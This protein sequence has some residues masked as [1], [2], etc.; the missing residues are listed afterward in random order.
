MVSDTRQDHA[1]SWNAGGWFGSQLGS[2]LWLA[3]SAAVL[4]GRSAAVASIVFTLFLIINLVGVLLWR[5]RS[6]MSVFLAM[7]GLLAVFWVSSMAAIF[8]ID[9]AGLW[10]TLAV[11][12]RNNLSAPRT[13][14]LLTVLVLALGVMFRFR[15]RK[16]SATSRDGV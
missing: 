10:E 11:G 13:Y 1:A 14:V 15:E 9:R 16:R 6:R 12:A 8:V 4:A 7:Q 5:R 3:I 2:T